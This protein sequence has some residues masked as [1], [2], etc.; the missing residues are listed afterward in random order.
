MIERVIDINESSLAKMVLEFYIGEIDEDDLKSY[1][2][3]WAKKNNYKLPKSIRLLKDI[4]TNDEGEIIHIVSET[5]NEIYFHDGWDRWSY[6]NKNEE[7]LLFEY[8]EED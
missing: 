7:G 1:F 8:I 2:K 5:E 4:V 6:L 3:K